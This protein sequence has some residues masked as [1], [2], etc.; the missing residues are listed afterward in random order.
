MLQSMPILHT[1]TAD[2]MRYFD[3]RSVTRQYCSGEIIFSEGE[4]SLSFSI[5]VEGAIEIIKSLGTPDERVIKVL[6]AGEFMGEMSLLHH[7]R[8]RTASARALGAVAMTEIPLDDFEVLVKQNAGLAYTLMEVMSQRLRETENDVIRDLQERNRQLAHSLLELAAAQESLIA[9]EKLE[10]ELNMARQIQES[11]LPNEL[12]HLPGWSLAVHWQPAR[13]VSGDFYDFF[14]LPDGR[15]VLIV[16]DVTDKGVPA[17]LI[18]TVT[19]SMLRTATMQAGC[20]SDL[21]ERVNQLLC[22]EMP[23]SMF[24][25]CFVAFLSPEDGHMTYANA[26]HCLPVLE[27]NGTLTELRAKGMPLGLLPDMRYP[28]EAVDL[29]PG[30][31]LLFYSDGLVEAHSPDGEMFGKSA[32]AAAFA[33]AAD[34][35]ALIRTLLQ[36]WHSFSGGQAEQEDDITLVCLEREGNA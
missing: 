33:S 20:P 26:G 24:V 23:Q 30:D 35:P 8:H 11:M 16:G 28:G 9:K 32:F 21:L 22:P 25:T 18:M 19:R 5:I 7:E 15:L 12:P 34:G 2:E 6:P 4:E 13:A 29:A 36:Q 10:V 17:A 3:E 27:R 14:S 1:L 31:R